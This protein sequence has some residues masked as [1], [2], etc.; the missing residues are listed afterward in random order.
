MLLPFVRW[1]LRN[2]PEKFQ[3]C[4]TLEYIFKLSNFKPL[5]IAAWNV[6]TQF[7]VQFVCFG[8]THMSTVVLFLQMTNFWLSVMRAYRGENTHFVEKCGRVMCFFG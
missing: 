8:W 2:L 6:S 5:F 7:M 1:E 4:F 3:N